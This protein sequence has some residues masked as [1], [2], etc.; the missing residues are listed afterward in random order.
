MK[1]ADLRPLPLC[2][3]VAGSSLRRPG[4]DGR[5][6]EEVGRWRLLRF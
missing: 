2:T 1:G 6:K 5:M 4:T 3:A